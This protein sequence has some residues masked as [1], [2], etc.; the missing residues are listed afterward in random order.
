MPIVRTVVRFLIACVLAVAVAGIAGLALAAPAALARP[1][2]LTP[3]QHQQSARTMG[4]VTSGLA[5]SI[6][7]VSPRFAS[8]NATIMVTGTITNHTG[9]PLNGVQVLLQ[10]SSSDFTS[11]SE[12]SEFSSGQYLALNDVT[13]PGWNAPGTLHSNATMSWHASFPAGSQGYTPY[14][15]YPIEAQALSGTFA[16]LGDARTFL[17]YWPASGSGAPKKLDISWIWPLMDAPQQGACYQDLATNEAASSLAAGGRL[18]NLLA[19]GL[20]YYA[21]RDDLTWAV[22]PALLSDASVMTQRYK[23]GGD[24]ECSASTGMPASR[25]ASTWLTELQTRTRDEQMFVTPYADPDVSAL[26]HAWTVTWIAPTRS[27][28]ARRTG[29][30]AGRSEL[31]RLPGPPMAPPTRACWPAWPAAARSPPPCSIAPR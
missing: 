18:S 4:A 11:R 8:A 25:A 22:D 31:A 6:N 13:T 17:P 5:V 23:V 28:I 2:A 12:M 14:G 30:L 27:G 24:A 10:T 19:T 7:S 1:A 3:D 26:V 9:G 15:V 16:P 29:S 20:N 21:D